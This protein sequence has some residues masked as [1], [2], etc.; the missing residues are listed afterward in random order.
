MLCSQTN[1]KEISCQEFSWK[2]LENG[3][4]FVYG[5]DIKY[6]QV[7]SI[8]AVIHHTDCHILLTSLS[9]VVVLQFEHA[10]CLRKPTELT[11][12]HEWTD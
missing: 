7:W 9:A 1:E 10:Y 11:T 5:R 3:K 6:N 8:S 2:G 4:W 12:L